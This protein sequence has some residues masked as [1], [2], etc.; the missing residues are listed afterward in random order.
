[1]K[2]YGC[3]ITEFIIVGIVGSLWHFFYDW[4]NENRGLLS[5]PIDYC[6][7]PYVM[8]QNDNMMS[9]NNCLAVDL[10]GQVCAESV[11]LRQISG[12]GGQLDYLT[13]ASS[14]KGGKAFICMTSTFIDHEGRRQSRIKPFF[15]GDIV[16]DPR[17]QTYLLVTEYG[18]VNLVGRTTWERAEML[19]SSAQPDCRD[20]LIR[21]AEEQK[22]WRRS[23]KR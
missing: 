4:T 21:A 14:S 5:A 17:S 2:K 22:I 20:G 8:A 3:Y 23:N 10:Y 1:M 12:T 18:V 6:N 11:G 19:V 9:I 16:T 7:D 13:G 15:N